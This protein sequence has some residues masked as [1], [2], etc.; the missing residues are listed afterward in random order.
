MIYCIFLILLVITF[1]NIALTREDYLNP[2]VVF[3]AMFTLFSFTCCLVDF[4]IDLEFSNFLT[5][6]LIIGGTLIFT[7][8]NLISNMSAK[9]SVP[10]ERPLCRDMDAKYIILF[11]VLE[12]FILFNMYRHINN[13]AAAYGV[14][15]N[16]PTKLVFYD[17]ITKFNSDYKL[18]MPAYVSIGNLLGRSISYLS[19][20]IMMKKF[21]FEKKLL[22]CHMLIIAIYGVG[23][24]MGGRTEA[25]RIITAAFFMWYVFYKKKNGWTVGNFKMAVKIVAVAIAV[26]VGFSLMRGML[27]RTTYDPIKVVFGYMGASLKNLD[28]FLNNPNKSIHGIFGAMTFTKFINWIGSKFNVPNLIYVSDQPFLYFKD[29]RMGNVYTTYY[30]F[31][32]DFG[33]LGCI[34]LV[35]IM[36]VFFVFSYKGVKEYDLGSKIINLR[37]ITYAYLFNDLI[38]L[39]FSSRFYETVVNINFIRLTII[40]VILTY[41]INSLAFSIGGGKMRVVLRR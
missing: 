15:G 4:K 39:P 10:E 40:T 35:T 1:L 21:V 19:L 14:G 33:I 24:L 11:I 7:V 25:L 2:A 34:V 12:M 16:F 3:S 41:V 30:N 17:T 36:A 29:Y 38:M 13:F 26:V 6:I 31:Y 18:R 8:I 27:G 37:I 32:Y 9:R 22:L 23:S 28:T 20:Y 5:F